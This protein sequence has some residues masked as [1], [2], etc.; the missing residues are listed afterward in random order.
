MLRYIYYRC[1]KHHDKG[2]R[3]NKIDPYWSRYFSELIFIH[4]DSVGVSDN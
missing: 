4:Y 3:Q 2:K 1:C